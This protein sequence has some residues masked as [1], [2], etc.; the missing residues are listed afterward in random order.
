MWYLDRLDMRRDTGEHVPLIELA[1]AHAGMGNNDEAI[2]LLVTAIRDGEPGVFS[3]RS[4]PVWDQLRRDPR[5]RELGRQSQPL[6]FRPRRPRG[7]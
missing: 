4:D 5:L 2:D 7:G 6:R 1:T 3:I